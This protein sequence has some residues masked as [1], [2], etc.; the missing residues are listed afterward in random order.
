MMI[1][2]VAEII[3]G[4]QPAVAALVEEVASWEDMRECSTAAAN[5]V[6]REC[7]PY[8]GCADGLFEFVF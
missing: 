4:P 8:C 5:T 6:A 7:P 3:L 2:E 1:H